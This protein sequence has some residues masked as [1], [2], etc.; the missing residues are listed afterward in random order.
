MV[1]ARSE[2]GTFENICDD[3]GLPEIPL[4]DTFLWSLIR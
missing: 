1:I 4:D 2:L 3:L